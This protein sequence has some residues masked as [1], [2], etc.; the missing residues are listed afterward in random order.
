MAELL[1]HQK[2]VVEEQAELAARLAKLSLF[3]NSAFFAS[4][5][6]AEQKRLINQETAMTLYDVILH[7]RIKAFTPRPAQAED[8]EMGHA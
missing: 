3:I 5:D 4:V 2:R 8:S 1:P 7:E 6:H